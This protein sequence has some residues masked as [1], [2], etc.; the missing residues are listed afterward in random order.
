MNHN[1]AINNLIIWFHCRHL[2]ILTLDIKGKYVIAE[3]NIR[4]SQTTPNIYSNT[5]TL[6]KQVRCFRG[7]QNLLTQIQDA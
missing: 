5:I 1:K 3:I 4:K 6:G 2:G 7:R